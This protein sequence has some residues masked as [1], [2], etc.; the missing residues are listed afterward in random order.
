MCQQAAAHYREWPRE[1]KRKF[2]FAES[3]WD[4]AGSELSVVTATARTL[5]NPI[6]RRFSDGITDFAGLVNVESYP[7]SQC[8]VRCTVTRFR[9][10]APP[11]YSDTIA[12]ST[13][14]R[15]MSTL[16][17]LSGT[18]N[19]ALPQF[20][21]ISTLGKSQ[22]MV[23]LRLS[24]PEKCIAISVG[25]DLRGDSQRGQNIKA[26]PC[27]VGSLSLIGRTEFEAQRHSTI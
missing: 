8:A 3:K 23:F 18:T 12:P 20:K 21:Q 10:A 5:V 27:W 9:L 14:L 2:A 11:V 24:D 13:D 4:Q 22:T 7:Q 26:S 1:R 19:S 16:R 6:A 15:S 17:S 25:K